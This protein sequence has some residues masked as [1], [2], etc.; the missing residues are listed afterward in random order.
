ME[1]MMERKLNIK[2]NV[3][4][5]KI[6]VCSRENNIRTRI[7]LIGVSPFLLLLLLYNY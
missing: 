5:T 4:N 2:I 1:V 6:L 3:M 7:K